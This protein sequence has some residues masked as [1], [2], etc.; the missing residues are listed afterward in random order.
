MQR[1]YLARL[2]AAGALLLATAGAV[3]PPTA[4]GRTLPPVATHLTGQVVDPQFNPPDAPGET[5]SDVGVAAT[6]SDEPVDFAP[7]ETG[8]DR[9]D[10]PASNQGN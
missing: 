6:E 1:V 9:Q 7:G 5:T 4:A 3:S 8:T 2:I 10:S